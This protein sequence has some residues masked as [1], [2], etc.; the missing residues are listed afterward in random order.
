MQP[1]GERGGSMPGCPTAT[2]SG[3]RVILPVST[4]RTPSLLTL[5]PKRSIRRGAVLRA[6][7]LDA[8]P[9]V[10]RPVAR[11]LEPEVL[12]ARVGLAAEMR[13]ALV[14]RADVDVHAIAGGVLAR[15]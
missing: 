9:V 14:Q 1:V 4:V 11:A 8:Q 3:P 6:C 13:A 10:A 15:D 2:G 12:E 5:T 7:R